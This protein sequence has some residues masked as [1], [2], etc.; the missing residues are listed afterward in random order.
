MGGSGRLVADLV[1]EGKSVLLLG[2]PGERAG[3]GGEGPIRRGRAGQRGMRGRTEYVACIWVR[4]GACTWVRY[5]AC[6]WVRYG[7]CI[8]VRYVACV[9]VR[10]VA[11][12]WVRYGACM[13]VRYVAC[14][15]VR[16]VACVIIIIIKRRSG[17]N[18]IPPTVIDRD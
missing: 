16:Y 4:Y 12:I 5:D 13:W 8:W 14:I 18:P 10:Y 2:R 15:W 7:A 9:W 3:G 6:I 17:V 11:C 1:Q